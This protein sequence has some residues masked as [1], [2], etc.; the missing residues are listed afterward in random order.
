[1]VT[2]DLRLVIS[3]T[4][5]N[6]ETCR[7]VAEKLRLAGALTCSDLLQL[8]E[9][10]APEDATYLPTWSFFRG[11]PCLLNYRIDV[12]GGKLLKS[13]TMETMHKLSLLPIDA[14]IGYGPAHGHLPIAKDSEDVWKLVQTLWPKSDHSAQ[15]MIFM[16]I[17]RAGARNVSDLIKLIANEAPMSCLMPAT[18]WF[19]GRTCM[20]NFNIDQMGGKLFTSST[21]ETIY[22]RAVYQNMFAEYKPKKTASPSS[23]AQSKQDRKRM[24]AMLQDQA[25]QQ[26]A[27]L[28]L[29]Q[30]LETTS[31]EEAE[32][33]F[34]ITK[35]NKVIPLM[36]NVLHAAFSHDS[37]LF[38]LAC[39]NGKISIINAAQDL[40]HWKPIHSAELNVHHKA[41]NF[42]CFRPVDKE[43]YL[44]QYVLAAAG[45]DG[46]V[47]IWNLSNLQKPE[48]I[49]VLD[50]GG[51]CVTTCMFSVCGKLL[52]SGDVQGVCRIFDVHGWNPLDSNAIRPR[53]PTHDWNVTQELIGHHGADRAINC[54][55]F[56][57]DSGMLATASMDMTVRVWQR[58]F[59]P[60]H[61]GEWMTSICI[62]FPGPVNFIQFAPGSLQVIANCLN[63]DRAYAWDLG[64]MQ[65]QEDPWH[66]EVLDCGDD[67]DEIVCTSVAWTEKRWWIAI[68]LEAGRI[69]LWCAKPN[70]HFTQVSVVMNRSDWVS[71]CVSFSPDSNFMV[72]INHIKPEV[73]DRRVRTAGSEDQ[74]TD[75]D[76]AFTEILIYDLEFHVT[77]HEH[78]V[79]KR[80]GQ[81]T[82]S[83]TLKSPDDDVEVQDIVL[84]FV[85]ETSHVWLEEVVAHVHKLM[86]KDS[87]DAFFQLRSKAQSV[88]DI[89]FERAQRTIGFLAKSSRE[90]GGGSALPGERE[91]L[92][93]V[94]R[95]EAA[96]AM[97]E[98][99]SC[100]RPSIGQKLNKR[101]SSRG[102]SGS[103]NSPQGPVSPLFETNE[104]EEL[105]R[106]MCMVL[107]W[108]ISY[109]KL[110]QII[111]NSYVFNTNA[112]LDESILVTS[113][114]RVA[115]KQFKSEETEPALIWLNPALP[116]GVTAE[117]EFLIEKWTAGSPE[118]GL[119]IGILQHC[120]R[121]GNGRHSHGNENVTWLY[122]CGTGMCF[123]TKDSTKSA[124]AYTKHKAQ[125]GDK[126]AVMVDRVRGTVSIRING[127]NQGTMIDGIPQKGDIHFAVQFMCKNESVRISEAFVTSGW[128]NE[129]RQIEIDAL[130]F[131]VS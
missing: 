87:M 18:S 127:Q 118:D 131:K 67:R 32:I 42:C 121:V 17:Q 41:V 93:I 1:M 35:P 43:S 61:E 102:Q 103:V 58:N 47:S 54:I 79:D 59:E 120:K 114:G 52:A 40:Q 24:K 105:K 90:V 4:W 104:E 39:A 98:Q 86:G 38:A 80:I 65:K 96:N 63:D 119:R 122:G 101:K 85:R 112:L 68:G 130:E 75:V 57:S 13:A 84:K 46:I 62:H 10:A 36:D 117:N 28:A 53:R 70:A 56:T 73:R 9:K 26:R 129:P 69:S 11:R 110:F 94:R 71:N 21:L 95:E 20:L 12:N 5:N 113:N 78:E 76:E 27:R 15:D 23:T 100:G 3:R 33:V 51:N 108:L 29:Q 66:Y 91:S 88:H 125:E 22:S 126:L 34:E 124:M 44:P 74:R 82:S 31:E 97:T 25:D 45:S 109:P 30:A 14:E 106:R 116:E 72:C 107:E 89:A 128:C 2:D 7:R 111:W 6:V 77:P 92:V 99:T 16:K 55:A 50:H 81:S 123:R 8:M 49:R 19:R 48:C 37:Q 60:P 115:T 64:S 83:S